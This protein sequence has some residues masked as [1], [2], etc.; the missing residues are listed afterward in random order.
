ME[1]HVAGEV[2]L[3]EGVERAPLEHRRRAPRRVVGAGGDEAPG[4]RALVAEAAPPGELSERALVVQQLVSSSRS[5][6]SRWSSVASLYGSHC[7][8]AHS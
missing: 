2:R 3:G 7:D 4:E 6:C 5:V 8:I 1:Q